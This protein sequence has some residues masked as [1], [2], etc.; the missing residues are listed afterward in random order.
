M[1]ADKGEE[2]T[3]IGGRTLFFVFMSVIIVVYD[4]MSSSDP[5]ASQVPSCI[6]VLHCA[7]IGCC[8]EEAVG[9]R[10]A[11]VDDAYEVVVSKGWDGC[12]RYL[13]VVAL[14]EEHVLRVDAFGRAEVFTQ[15]DILQL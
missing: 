7:A 3:P 6:A 13:V 11:A 1:D 15:D 8:G 5:R 14:G 10:G 9:Q 4:W 2:G 12:G